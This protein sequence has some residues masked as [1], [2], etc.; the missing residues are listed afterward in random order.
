ME[1]DITEVA[2]PTTCI[3]LQGRLDAQGADRIGTRFTA[4]AAAGGR[5]AIVDLSG[6]T[7]VASLG[8]RLLISAARA[9]KSKG[10]TLVLFGANDLVQ[11]VLDHAEI[12]QIIPV[13]R[14]EHDALDRLSH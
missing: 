13:A 2:G 8:L 6:V 14:T 10:G 7:F 3:R 11:S 9:L 12:G 5:P 1:M 4:A